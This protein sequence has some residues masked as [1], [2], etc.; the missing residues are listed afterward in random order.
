MVEITQ[1]MH[2][3]PVSEVLYRLNVNSEIEVKLLDRAFD[4]ILSKPKSPV[5]DIQLGSILVGIISKGPKTEEVASLLRSAFKLDNFNP[6]NKHEIILPEGELL[7]GA[8]GSGKKGVKTM[9]ISTPALITAASLGVYTVKIASSATSSLTGSSDFLRAVGM[10]L[11]LPVEKMEKVVLNT[12]FGAFV[13]EG[14]IPKFDAVYAKKFY[15]PHAL[16]FGLAALVS[17]IKF[18][19]LL[20]GLAHPNVDLCV[21]VLNEFKMKNVM[22]ASTTHDGIHYLDEMGI[23]GITKIKGIRN[24]EIGKTKKFNPI[25]DLKLRVYGPDDI[26]EGENKVKNIKLAVDVLVEVCS[27]W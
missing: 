12:N 9:N 13:V 16:S 15:A 26:S 3:D 19:N 14:L 2:K 10:N 7:V 6:N 4:L 11:D 27:K 20:Y 17:P 23:Y 5:R 21:D 25:V 1:K 24:G 22:V 8:I 18:D